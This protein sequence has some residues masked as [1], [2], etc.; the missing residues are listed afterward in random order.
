MDDALPEE[1]SLFL[2][3]IILIDKAEDL[4]NI[5]EK[6]L[7]DENA[8]IGVDCEAAIEMSRF[9]KLCLIQVTKL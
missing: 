2:S 7:K 4:D 8:V 6:I 9:G 5:V 3:N 1:S